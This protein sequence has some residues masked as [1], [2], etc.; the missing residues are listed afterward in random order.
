M[1]SD[2]DRDWVEHFL[3]MADR[4]IVE[5]DRIVAK[6]MDLI[7]RMKAIGRDTECAETLLIAFEQCQQMHF[8]YRDRVLRESNAKRTQRRNPARTAKSSL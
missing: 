6:Q 1:L 5:G 7:A 2:M 8:E 3:K 4:H